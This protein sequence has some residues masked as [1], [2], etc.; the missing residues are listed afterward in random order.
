MGQLIPVGCQEALPGDTFQLHTSALI[1]V[2]PLAAPVMHPVS[3]RVHHFFVP[4]RLVWSDWE[5]FIT[6]GPDGK[7]ASVI[8]T[9]P[10]PSVVKDTLWDHLGIPANADTVQVSD[11]PIR[12][13]NMI[14]NEYYR[15]QDLA[16]ER[17]LTDTTLPNIAWGK[18]YFTQARPWTQ[19]GDDVTVPVGGQGTVRT[20]GGATTPVAVGHDTYSA[21]Y[22]KLD[23]NNAVELRVGTQYSDPPA[24]NIL[25]A[26]LGGGSA[27]INDFRRAFALQRYQEARARY[28]S[29]YTEYLRYLG[30]TPSDARLQ[31]PEFIGGGNTRL[32]FSE[33]LQTTPEQPTGGRENFGVGDMFGHGIA[34]LRSGR[35]RRF[36]EEHGYLHSFISVRPRG[37]YQNG[38]NRH[39]LKTNREQF[40]QRELQHIGQQEIFQDEIYAQSGQKDVVFG[41]ADRYREYREHPSTVA[42]E[43]RSEL[44]FWHMARDL[45]SNTTLNEDFIKCV[46]T[47][48]VHNVQNR[49]ALWAMVNNHVVARR[50]VS[51]NASARLF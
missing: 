18:D 47:K 22:A 43:Y 34:A 29:R 32:N 7:D 39:F 26:D 45:P 4:H 40:W 19:K 38:I 41:Y 33:V 11:L 5:N 3:V 16:T 42:G 49:H 50:L 35:I 20:A 44:D 48:R 27:S 10:V 24:D 23:P 21:G 8:P 6:G 9:L 37:I 13:I 1:R 31:R 51:R 12:G 15:D 46:P 30:V 17:A 36:I 28:G 25:Y 14:W 2:S